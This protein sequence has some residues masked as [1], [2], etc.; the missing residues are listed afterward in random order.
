MRVDSVDRDVLENLRALQE[1]GERDF[2]SD[3]IDLFLLHSPSL[4]AT[5]RDSLLKK[6]AEALRRAAHTLKGSSANMGAHR[7]SAICQQLEDKGKSGLLDETEAIFLQL[8]AEF[9]DVREALLVEK[10]SSR[11]NLLE[12]PESA[13][14]A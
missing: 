14:N 10:E 13:N 2:L 12:V 3:L 9:D 7:M 5:M 1:E 8:Q 11:T 6:E 4:I